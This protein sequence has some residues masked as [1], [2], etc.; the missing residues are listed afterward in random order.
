MLSVNFVVLTIFGCG[1]VMW[2]TKI[3]PFILL[4]YLK[5]SK[6]SLNI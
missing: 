4:K 1:L 6:V 2:L 3:I 5:L